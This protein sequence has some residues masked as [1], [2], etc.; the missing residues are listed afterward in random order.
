MR[1]PSRFSNRRRHPS[2]SRCVRRIIAAELQNLLEETQRQAEELQ[3]QSE[4]LR[5]SNEELEEQG[6]ALKESQARLEQQ[7][8]ELEQTNSQLEEQ[9]QQLETQRDD[10]ERVNA[11]VHLKARELEQASRYKSDFLANMSH[12]LRTPLNSSL[13]PRQAACGQSERQPDRRAGQVCPDDP[14]V[15][16]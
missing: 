10:L 2:A 4:E 12:E 14:I 6:R 9:A 11:S 5:V 15:G 8:V 1:V 3:T 7:Q 16:Q 13:D